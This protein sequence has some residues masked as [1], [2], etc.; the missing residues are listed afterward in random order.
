MQISSVIEFFNMPS[1][2]RGLDEIDWTQWLGEIH[3]PK[4]V[5]KI[6]G[7]YE[8][9]MKAEYDVDLAV[10]KVG[11]PGAK[12]Q[13]LEIAATYNF[14]LWLCH[15]MNHLEQLETIRNIGDI[16]SMSTVE[17]LTLSPGMDVLQSMQQETGDITPSDIV[18]DGIYSRLCTQFSWGSQFNPAFVHSSDALNAVAATMGKLGK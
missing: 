5:E 2:N 8:G 1:L 7:K 13:K 18:E 6:R 3:T 15:Y 14:M 17:M 10:S 9:F 12:M 11:T 4:V 16:N